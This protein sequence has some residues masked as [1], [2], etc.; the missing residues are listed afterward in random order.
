MLLLQELGP[1]PSWLQF[2][3]FGLLCLV[4]GWLAIRAVPLVLDQIKSMLNE[5]R[6]EREAAQKRQDEERREH[7]AQMKEAWQEYKAENKETRETFKSAVDGLLIQQGAKLDTII[8]GH[9]EIKRWL[10]PKE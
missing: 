2:G 7:E 5:A 10:R 3:A 4:L 8:N 6:A 1:I 9:E